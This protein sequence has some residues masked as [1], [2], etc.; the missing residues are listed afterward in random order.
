MGLMA[1]CSKAK[2]FLTITWNCDFLCIIHHLPRLGFSLP[3]PLVG[4]LY[5]CFLGCRVAVTPLN[6]ASMGPQHGRLRR[7]EPLELG[8]VSS[9]PRGEVFSRFLGGYSC[10]VPGDSVLF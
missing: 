9:L 6:A 3:C 4:W 7:R 2:S 1:Q 8:A 10:V 5:F